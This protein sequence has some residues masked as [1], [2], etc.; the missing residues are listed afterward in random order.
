MDCK[1]AQELVAP[2][3]NGQLNTE[4]AEAFLEHVESCGECREELEVSYSL[5]TAIRQLENGTDLSDNYIVDLNNKIEECYLEGL[6]R[7]RACARRRVIL[8]TLILLLLFTN[9]ATVTKKRNEADERFL[10]SI[11]QMEINVRI[12]ESPE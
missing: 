7:K 6:R 9:G 4:D 12:K 1:R 5:M 2:F 8:V 3:I 10:R 11:E